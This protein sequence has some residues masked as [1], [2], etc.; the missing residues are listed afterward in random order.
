MSELQVLGGSL[1]ECL[2]LI[3]AAIKHA[4]TSDKEISPTT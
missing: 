1:S 4:V 3:W 2:T